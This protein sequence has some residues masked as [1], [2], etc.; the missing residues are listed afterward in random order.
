MAKRGRHNG[1]YILEGKVPVPCEDLLTWGRW[2][3]DHNQ[4]RIVRQET[5]GNKYFVST[6]FLGLDH[7]FSQQGP[8]VLFET[9]VFH[10]N[11]KRGSVD[12]APMFR[13]YTWELALTSHRKAVRWARKQLH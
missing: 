13:D 4:D 8:P 6:V 11:R 7:D 10:K 12:E 2:I 9:M 3:E 1:R 5:I